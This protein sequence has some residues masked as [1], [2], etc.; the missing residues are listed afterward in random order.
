MEQSS[1]PVDSEQVQMPSIEEHIDYDDNDG[2][3][4][5]NQQTVDT[6]QPTIESSL[7]PPRRTPTVPCT[8]LHSEVQ[9]KTD[10]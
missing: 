2:V 1:E 7:P 4:D 6:Q 9:A 5:D 10:N 3:D 8:L